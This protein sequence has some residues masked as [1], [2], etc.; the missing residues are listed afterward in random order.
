MED[1]TRER[2]EK[3]CRR[4]LRSAAHWADS[5]ENDKYRAYSWAYDRL[6][7]MYSALMDVYEFDYVELVRN[8]KQAASTKVD[9][10]LGL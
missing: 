1:K 2:L 7:G 9:E 6:D 4:I 8:Y 10:A 3:T 5:D